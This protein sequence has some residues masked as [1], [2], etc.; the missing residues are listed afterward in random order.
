MF[1]SRFWTI[2]DTGQSV[3]NSV[4]SSPEALK[5]QDSADNRCEKYQ[6]TCEDRVQ[7]PKARVDSA[8]HIKSRHWQQVGIMDKHSCFVLHDSGRKW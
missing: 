4:C 8:G 6:R 3:E 1:P 2:Y 5:L 7:N